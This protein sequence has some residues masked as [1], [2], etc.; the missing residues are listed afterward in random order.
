MMYM[1]QLLVGGGGDQSMS[2]IGSF[3]FFEILYNIIVMR[4]ISL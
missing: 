3:M 4:E 1:F 2:S